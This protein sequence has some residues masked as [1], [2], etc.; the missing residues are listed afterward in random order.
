MDT[1][2]SFHEIVKNLQS[3]SSVLFHEIQLLQ[4]KFYSVIK[5]CFEVVFCFLINQ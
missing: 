3:L 1:L 4:L 2:D 5:I